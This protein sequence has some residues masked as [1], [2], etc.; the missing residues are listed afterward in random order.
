MALGQAPAHVLGMV[1]RESL[2]TVAV[3]LLIGLAG[4]AAASRLLS[5]LLYEISPYDPVALAV[6]A[7][8]LLTVAVVASFIPARRAATVD[9]LITMRAD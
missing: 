4:A 6:T 7:L 5:S 3:G 8:T 9:P 1:L 2:A